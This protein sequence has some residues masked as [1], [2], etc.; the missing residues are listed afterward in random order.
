[1]Y[2]PFSDAEHDALQRDLLTRREKLRKAGTI[3]KRRMAGLL[4]LAIVGL[5]HV[6]RLIKELTDA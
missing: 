3:A 5:A 2:R 1:M 4:D 6:K